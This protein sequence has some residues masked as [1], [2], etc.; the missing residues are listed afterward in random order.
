MITRNQRESLTLDHMRHARVPE[1]YWKATLDD[2]PGGYQGLREAKVFCENMY[3]NLT[4]GIGL[5]LWGDVGH[6]KTHLGVAVLKRAQSFRASALFLEVQNIQGFVFERT[7]LDVLSHPVIEVAKDVDFLVL[8]DFGAEH[9]NDYAK[10]AV[11][12]LIRHRGMRNKSTLITMNLLMS[13]VKEIYGKTLAS[14][15][16]E[17]VFPICVEGKDW[18][19]D[20][21]ADISKQFEA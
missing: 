20:R 10:A 18:R 4:T 1:R 17:Y 15:L 7:V 6:G 21:A 9:A 16:T 11:E 19:E 13:D 12:L 5:L 14:A 8:D 2:F 3:D